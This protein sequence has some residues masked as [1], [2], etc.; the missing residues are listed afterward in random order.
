MKMVFNEINLYLVCL[1]NNHFMKKNYLKQFIIIFICLISI[2]GLSAQTKSKVSGRVFD[3]KGELLIGVP[4]F[5]VGSS[6]GTVTDNNG[7]YNIILTKQNATLKF[8]YVGYRSQE[9]EVSSKRIIDVKLEEDLRSLDEVVVV[10]YGS[11]KKASVV[12]AIS[13]I[14]PEK[15]L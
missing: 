9:I 15:L 11:Q 8:S 1:F 6:N 13:S 10:G 3:V 7:T 4:V 12:G 2:V 5:E 14:E